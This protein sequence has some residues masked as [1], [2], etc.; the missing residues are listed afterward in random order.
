MQSTR[1]IQRA[2]K[3]ELDPNQAQR[4]AFLRHAGACRFLYNLALE[5]CQ[6]QYEMAKA[7]K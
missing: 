6:T 2:Y 4:E 3:T 1:T 5:R 7:R